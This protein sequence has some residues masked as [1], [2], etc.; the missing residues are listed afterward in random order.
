MGWFPAHTGIGRSEIVLA[1]ARTLV[2]RA[3]DAS[4]PSFEARSIDDAILLTYRDTT[5]RYHIYVCKYSTAQPSLS[6]VE[7]R[8]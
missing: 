3:W 5:E 4:T 6:V 2:S 1:A 7:L 8:L